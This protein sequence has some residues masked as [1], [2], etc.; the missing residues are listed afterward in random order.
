MVTKEQQLPC[1]LVF[2]HPLDKQQKKDQHS[3]W[4]VRSSLS[5]D[6]KVLPLKDGKKRYEGNSCC[7]VRSCP[8]DD[9]CYLNREVHLGLRS[10][11]IAGDS[12]QTEIEVEGRRTSCKL[13]YDPKAS[14]GNKNCNCSSVFLLYDVTH[15][16]NVLSKL[17]LFP[18]LAPTIRLESAL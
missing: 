4:L 1:D 13:S 18:L 10:I 15:V 12:S 14:Y 6:N 7:L 11:C 9:S 3:G 2:H 8:L 17:L 16:L 5:N